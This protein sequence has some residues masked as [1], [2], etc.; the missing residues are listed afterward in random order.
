MKSLSEKVFV[1]GVDGMDPRMTK[2]DKKIFGIR[3]NA[4]F[5]GIY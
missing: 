5:G 1:L 3:K 4:T 2:N